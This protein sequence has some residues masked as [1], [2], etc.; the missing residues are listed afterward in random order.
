MDGCSIE[1]RED[2]HADGLEQATTLTAAGATGA[3]HSRADVDYL[4]W[5][6]AV[7]GMYAFTI[8]A[9]AEGAGQIIPMAPS[10]VDDQGRT[11]EQL[12]ADPECRF[13]VT[14]RAGESVFLRLE[15]LSE[16]AIQGNYRISVQTTCG[17]G[18]VEDHESCD[19]ADPSIGSFSCRND[20]EWRR[21]MLNGWQN[22]CYRQDGVAW[23]TGDAGWSVLGPAG[24]HLAVC[25]GY[26]NQEQSCMRRPV[27]IPGC[28]RALALLH[29][30]RLLLNQPYRGSQRRRRER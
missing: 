25:Q 5:S 11:L 15:P 30:V 18:V 6:A 23:C 10:L 27:R 24:D 20:C 29:C 3:I 7:P 21:S 12:A 22:T 8:E 28:G 16:E 13:E 26:R 14:L 4:R 1:C 9:V 2:D 17:N 19:Y